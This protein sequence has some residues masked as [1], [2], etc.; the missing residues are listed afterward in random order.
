MFPPPQPPP[1]KQQRSQV[2]TF[3][4][5]VVGGSSASS[6]SQLQNHSS[7]ASRS[8]HDDEDD[9]MS[10][11]VP[12][13]YPP[14]TQISQGK[15]STAS[16]ELVQMRNKIEHMKRQCTNSQIVLDNNHLQHIR[17]IAANQTGEAYWN[18]YM[19]NKIRYEH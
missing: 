16:T 8:H 3:S 1:K 14:L 7:E 4:N 9:E 17:S 13:Q 10:G 5:S 6:Q 12:T 2:V 19:A 18:I 11:H 15:L